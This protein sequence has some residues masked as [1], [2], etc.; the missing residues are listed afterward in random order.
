M[1]ISVRKK[2]ELGEEKEGI[3]YLFERLKLS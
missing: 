3:L 1:R 2:K